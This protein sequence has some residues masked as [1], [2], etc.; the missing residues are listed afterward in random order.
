MKMGGSFR[1]DDYEVHFVVCIRYVDYSHSC[2]PNL[3]ATCDD[4]PSHNTDSI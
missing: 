2:T 1:S 3:A 4:S